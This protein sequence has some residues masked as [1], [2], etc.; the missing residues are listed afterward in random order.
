MATYT[1]LGIKQITTG[2]E[3]GTWGTST[4]TN[5]TYFDNA[6]VGY[7]AT[8]YTSTGT[9]GAP[10]TLP[11][12][13][14]AASN[15]RN[16]LIEFT[17]TATG[18][19]YVQ[20]TPATFSGYYFVRNS[21]ANSDVVIFQGT[22]SAPNSL[23]LPVGKDC[24]IRCD[25]AGTPVVSR[26]YDNP[27]LSSLFIDTGRL[28]LGDDT[29]YTMVNTPKVQISSTGAGT[30]SVNSITWSATSASTAPSIN[31][32]RSKGAANVFTAVADGD[33]LGAFRTYGSDGT[34]FRAGCSIVSRVDGTPTAG[35]VP[36]GID[37]LTGIATA[38]PKSRFYIAP[39]GQALIGSQTSNVNDIIQVGAVGA[40]LTTDITAT[41]V[42]GLGIRYNTPT[43]ATSYA[44][45]IIVTQGGSNGTYTTSTVTGIQLTDYTPGSGQTV[46]TQHGV[47]V[48]NII[49]ATSNY[50]IW[51]NL[52]VG[53]GKYNIYTSTADSQFGGQVAVGA[54][55][56]SNSKLI[57]NGNDAA[58]FVSGNSTY[59]YTGAGTTG[60]HG[61][62]NAFSIA[63]FAASNATT[64]TNASTVYVS[65]PPA[66]GANVTIT[67]PY[68]IFVGAGNV[69]VNDLFVG[70][71]SSSPGATDM[72]FN[73]N[74]VVKKTPTAT[75][76]YTTTVPPAGTVCNLI[77]STSGITSY[78]ITFGTGFSST[79]TLAT[80]TVSGKLYTV[81]FVSDG[82]SLIETGRTGPI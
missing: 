36:T 12:T 51:S 16:R 33:W 25:G 78:T 37:F 49:G 23:T 77:I 61:A 19:H 42:N 48:D 13:N 14:F 73:T 46:T 39:T 74:N 80:G 58:N 9:S 18:T 66:A 62:T 35:F 76:T 22:Y 30:S 72:G 75:A 21:I 5:F 8:A 15:G 64:Y 56:R 38:A 82:T 41:V 60:S 54:T 26:V 6:I 4:N 3:A 20:I 32:G 31:L 47:Y 69:K 2:D 1:N 28:M 71:Y 43:T 27:V 79:G 63:T 53:T 52:S 68:S 57:T 59:T 70:G 55:T 50:G 10:N 81:N 29:V 34:A 17:S 67:N 11:V 7:V 40:T 45:G 44:R 24:I 65:G